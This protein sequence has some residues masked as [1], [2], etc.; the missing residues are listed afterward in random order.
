M[1]GSVI[2]GPK[3]AGRNIRYEFGMKNVHA[4]HEDR[5]K[6]L[7]NQ[8]NELTANPEVHLSKV[9]AVMDMLLMVGVQIWVKQI[10]QIRF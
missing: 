9:T 4:E 3:V 2:L 6:R 7:I 8:F 1:K 5:V 10:D